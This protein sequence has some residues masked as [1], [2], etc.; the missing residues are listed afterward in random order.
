MSSRR[1]SPA[2]SFPDSELL[3]SGEPPLTFHEV[4]NRFRGAYSPI[5]VTLAELEADAHAVHRRLRQESPVAVCAELDALLVLRWADV[6]TVVSKSSPFRSDQPDSFLT[7][8]IGPNMLHSEGQEH[9]VA[10]AA[11]LPAFRAA[12]T[13]PR[14]DAERLYSELRASRS[15]GSLCDLAAELCVPLA[16]MTSIDVLGCE[17]CVTPDQMTRWGSSLSKAAFD[18][19]ASSAVREQVNDTRSEIAAMV[20][21]FASGKRRARPDTVLGCLARMSSSFTEIRRMTELM[22][23]GGDTGPRQGI[24]TILTCALLAE[25]DVRTRLAHSPA[26]RQSFIDEALRWESPIGAVTREA[27]V[28]TELGGI[29]IERGTRVLGV[30]SSANRDPARWRQPDTFIADRQDRAHLSF[31]AGMH[32]C[33]GAALTRRVAEAIITVVGPDTRVRVQAAPEFR[34][35]WFRGPTALLVSW[36][37]AAP[38]SDSDSHTP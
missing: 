13:Q 20:A 36:N 32:G 12:G 34:G 24:S 19:H 30:L 10:R 23:I 26:A 16:A 18:F 15:D 2:A 21:A 27:R 4:R 1:S 14:A 31:G 8:F 9:H 38:P 35:W 28:D 29:K 22:I 37:Q 5:V 33:V 3:H 7:R 17:D 25:T 11:V 6:V